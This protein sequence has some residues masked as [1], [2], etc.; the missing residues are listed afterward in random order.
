[1]MPGRPDGGSRRSAPV[2]PARFPHRSPDQT[3]AAY[4]FINTSPRP[5][6]STAVSMVITAVALSL[7]VVGQTANPGWL[8]QVGVGQI[9]LLKLLGRIHGWA[10]PPTANVGSLDRT[11]GP[12]VILTGGG[13]MRSENVLGR[14]D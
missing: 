4:I 2:L 3:V 1:M 9:G 14:F 12:P 5:A 11:T 6:F 10:Y 8:I 13:R 7:G